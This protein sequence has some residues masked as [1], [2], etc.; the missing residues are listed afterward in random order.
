MPETVTIDQIR[1]LIKAEKLKPSDLFGAD[2]LADDPSVKGLVDSE[3]KRAVAGEY[4]HRKRTEE[5][6]DKTRR[7]LEAKITERDEKIKGL[8]LDAAKTQ[9][10]PLFQKQKETRKL[11]EK[12][13][14]YIEAR[15]PNFVPQKPEEFEKEFNAYLDS[16]LDQY[17]K[18]AK[19]FGVETDAGGG[20]DKAGGTGSEAD[21]N[22][23]GG[24]EDKYTDPA[25]NPFIK[26][27]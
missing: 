21:K 18:D 27:D 1:D 15:L 19:V 7:E 9:A 10:G 25:K 16:Q 17:G 23:G 14:A 20:K 6:F 4:A 3:N 11:N 12:Q 5:G 2:I 13:A 8:A 26:T 24:A 22:K